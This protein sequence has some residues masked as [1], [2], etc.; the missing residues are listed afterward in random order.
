M[1]E[2]ISFADRKPENNE[3]IKV[4]SDNLWIGEGIFQDGKFV[5]AWVKGACFRS[6]THWKSL[7][8]IYKE[9]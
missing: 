1:M 7:P 8:D 4:K 2:W 6:P 3:R 9:M 5:Y